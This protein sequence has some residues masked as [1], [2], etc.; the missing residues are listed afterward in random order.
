MDCNILRASRENPKRNSTTD[1]KLIISSPYEPDPS[2][3]TIKHRLQDAGLHV[4]RPTKKPLI[5]MKN[6]EI[7]VEWAKLHLYWRSEEWAKIVWGDEYIWKWWFEMAGS[8]F[9]PQYQL[10]LMEHGGRWNNVLTAKKE[11]AMIFRR[12]LTLFT[13]TADWVFDFIKDD[14]AVKPVLLKDKA[15]LLHHTYIFKFFLH[16]VRQIYCY[17]FIN[18]FF[19]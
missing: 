1:T 19:L 8:R 16:R 18:G 6:C 4:R 5:S 14:Q 12:E 15:L 7:R 13:S 9:Q 10:P 11:P 2:T 3:R 17:L